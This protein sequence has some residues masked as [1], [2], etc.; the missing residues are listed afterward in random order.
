MRKEHREFIG[1]MSDQKVTVILPV[2]NQGRTVARCLQSLLEQTYD[3]VEIWVGDD[4][5]TDNTRGVVSS[6]PVKLFKF[7]HQGRPRI[8]NRLLPLAETE[9]VAIV[10]GD[11][12]YE[13]NYLEACVRHFSSPQVGGVIGRQ[14]AVE[15]DSLVSR[16]I[17]TY[18]KVRWNLVDR[19]KYLA[20]TAWV[21]RREALQDV[22]GF[23]ED[24]SIAD[25]A[26]AGI[27]LMR[28]GW[29]IEFEKDTA[30]YHHEPTAIMTLI[31]QQFR[32][33]VGSYAFLK[34]Y[35]RELSNPHVKVRWKTLIGFY[36]FL[37]L[38]LIAS[39]FKTGL[40]V[41]ASLVLFYMLVRTACFMLNARMVTGDT[42]GALLFPTIDLLGKMA[43]SI[44]FFFGS[45][46][47]SL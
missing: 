45:L 35:G 44:G 41:L 27:S 7:K 5:S 11:A 20:S 16:A 3:G 46:G 23:D 8:L 2:Y 26:A 30:W 10:E 37:S 4:G 29:R 13:P 39:F 40:I 47:A 42:L 25:D 43:F 15:C 31:R 32:W 1:E 36:G 22:G 21:F 18:R 28:Y 33:G 9:F 34:K 38:I 14:L 19:P 17:S 6:F 12:V 24:L